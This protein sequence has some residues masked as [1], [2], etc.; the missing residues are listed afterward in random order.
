[1]EAVAHCTKGL[2]VLQTLPDTPARVRRE[3]DLQ[4]ALGTA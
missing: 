4:V 1:V 2:A 3:L